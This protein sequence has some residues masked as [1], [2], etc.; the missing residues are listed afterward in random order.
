MYLRSFAR[1]HAV[2]LPCV[3]PPLSLPLV[4]RRYK[5]DKLASRRI[6]AFGPGQSGTNV[7]LNDSLPGEVNQSL[8]SD[9]R[10]HVVQGFQWGCR[11]GPLCD[12]PLRNVKFKLQE[13]SIATA[14]IQRGG[15]QMIPTARRVAYSAFLLAEPRLMEPVYH[16]EVV[17]PADVV[18]AV[19][20]VLSRRRGHVISEAPLPGSPLYIV[21]G[22][23]LFVCFVFVCLF[24]VCVGHCASPFSRRRRAAFP[25]RL[26]CTRGSARALRLAPLPCNCTA[27]HLAPASLPCLL[28]TLAMN[29]NF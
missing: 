22:C 8:L 13:A 28:S 9:I 27:A 19:G 2:A 5:W 23:V 14:A 10:E 11:E 18:E 4:R 25:A 6:W 24:F 3:R 21:Q 16:V 17:A 15:G 12:E 1:A 29:N 20:T 26:V 7:L